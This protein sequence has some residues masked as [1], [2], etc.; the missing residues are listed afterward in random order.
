MVEIQNLMVFQGILITEPKKLI[1]LVIT[2]I[3]LEA[4][5]MFQI[6]ILN[7]ILEILSIIFLMK[8]EIEIVKENLIIKIMELNILFLKKQV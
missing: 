8:L 3:T 4:M 5:K 1:F 6:L 7:T 2:V